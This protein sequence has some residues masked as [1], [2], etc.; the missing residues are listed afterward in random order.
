MIPSDSQ[1]ATPLHYGA[2]SNYAVRPLL[3]CVLC[4]IFSPLDFSSCC[5]SCFYVYVV[6]DTVAVFLKHHTVR[7]EPDLEGRTAFM[8][9][10][11]K[12]SDDV[13]KIMLD[14]KQD[15]DINMADK[16]GGTGVEETHT[17]TRLVY[18]LCG[19]SS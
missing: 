7:D 19:N 8:W 10:A 6:K 15:L 18:Y 9:A 2:Q 11:G 12:G 13:I 1:G 3:L 4:Q 16:Y 17:H 5:F 14:L